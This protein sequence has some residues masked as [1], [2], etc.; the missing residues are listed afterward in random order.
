MGKPTNI[1]QVPQ[2]SVF[3]YPGGKTWFVPCARKW[4]K[5]R[6]SK[7]RLLVEPFG[8]GGIITLTAINEDLVTRAL[9]VEKDPMIAVVWKVCLGPNA[10]KLAR[11][12]RN[13]KFDAKTVVEQIR[14]GQQSQDPVQMAFAVI[15]LN[16]IRR[17]GVM[18]NG[19][20]ILKTGENGNGL[21]SRWYPETLASRVEA[22]Y[23]LRD[24]IEFVEGDGVEVVS[25]Y[26]SRKS[27]VFFVDPPYT[28]AGKRI[29]SH[30]ELDHEALLK[31]LSKVIG[32]FIVTYDDTS[33]TRKWARATGLKCENINMKATSHLVK[34]E[35]LVGRDLSWVTPV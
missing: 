8:G 2:L 12:I 13:Y 28:E 10:A 1:A 27:A 15:L 25:D 35:L 17:G 26:A 11:A 19:A 4:L 5:A 18:A 14:S 33:Q 22:I 32:D 16:R 30:W 24:R 21:S 23:A 29:Y 6:P 20:G 9:L 31:R 3:R 34:Q 7:P